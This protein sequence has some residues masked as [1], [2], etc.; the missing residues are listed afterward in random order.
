MGIDFIIK[1]FVME[2]IYYEYFCPIMAV[3]LEKEICFERTRLF[4]CVRPILC[5]WK[6]NAIYRLLDR[7][8][9]YPRRTP[10]TIL[11]AYL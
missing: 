3:S 5:W 8:Y 9:I 10:L 11:M 1:E 7:I 2:Y 6:L 4:Y